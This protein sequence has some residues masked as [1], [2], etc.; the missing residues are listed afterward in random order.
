[1]YP[2]LTT[3]T[4]AMLMKGYYKLRKFPELSDHREVV[5]RAGKIGVNV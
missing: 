3:E 4:T 5:C 2:S 1:M